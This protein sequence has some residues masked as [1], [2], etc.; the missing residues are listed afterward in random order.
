MLERGK[1]DKM[2]GDVKKIGG[3]ICWR[4]VKE[5]KYAGVEGVQKNWG[6]VRSRG[7]KKMKWRGLQ[8]KMGGDV[9]RRIG[10]G[11]EYIEK[12]EGGGGVMP[13]RGVRKTK[14]WGG[15]A[16]KN[17]WWGNMPQR[18]KKDKMQGVF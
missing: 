17:W 10:Y 16:K 8:K 3:G 9:S 12:F 4:G 5:T 18:G 13:Q 7:V 15:G 11:G 2:L 1:E 14:F 6:R